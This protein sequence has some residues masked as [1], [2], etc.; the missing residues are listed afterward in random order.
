MF[1]P[2][3][4]RIQNGL[5]YIRERMRER[6]RQREK[7]G[8]GVCVSCSTLTKYRTLEYLIIGKIARLENV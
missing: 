1:K 6:E 5:F 4:Q 7:E 2:G 3:L 8:E